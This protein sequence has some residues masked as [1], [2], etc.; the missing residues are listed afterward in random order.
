MTAAQILKSLLIAA[1]L[2][3]AS[4][5][6]DDAVDSASGDGKTTAAF[7]VSDLRCQL[8]EGQVRCTFGS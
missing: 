3:C 4:A 8:V 6:A 1:L 2:I 5:R 7:K